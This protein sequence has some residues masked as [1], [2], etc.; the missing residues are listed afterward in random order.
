MVKL[1]ISQSE[2]DAWPFCRDGENYAPVPDVKVAVQPPP[3][4]LLNLIY[5]SITAIAFLMESNLLN[6]AAGAA[7]RLPERICPTCV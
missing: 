4:L 2:R 3:H 5:T 6:N 7:D 1:S